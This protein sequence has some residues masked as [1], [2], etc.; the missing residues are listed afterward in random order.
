M[1]KV[2]VDNNNLSKG[3][4]KATGQVSQSVTISNAGMT[5]LPDH[6]AIRMHLEANK[7][8]VNHVIRMRQDTSINN[9]HHVTRMHQEVSKS[10]VNQGHRAIRMHQGARKT[11]INKGVDRIATGIEIVTVTRG[12]VL[13]AGNDLHKTIHQNDI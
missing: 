1:D 10:N 7:N 6:H 2:L 4:N 11:E 13:K 5:S 3:E 9:D 12:L 8:H